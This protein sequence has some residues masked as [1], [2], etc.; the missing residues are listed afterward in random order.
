MMNADQRRRALTGA[1]RRAE[2]RGD[3]LAAVTI[4]YQLDMLRTGR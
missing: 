1:L 2:R 3:K 4:R